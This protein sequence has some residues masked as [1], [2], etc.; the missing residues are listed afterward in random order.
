MFVVVFTFWA[1]GGKRGCNILRSRPGVITVATF[2]A[3]GLK[4]C[5][6]GGKGFAVATF[7][8]ALEIILLSWVVWSIETTSGQYPHIRSDGELPWGIKLRIFAASAGWRPPLETLSG[9]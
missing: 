6:H 3:P 1:F 2:F 4:A 5:A 7:W 8:V 9:T